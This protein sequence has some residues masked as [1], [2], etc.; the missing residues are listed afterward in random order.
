MHLLQYQNYYSEISCQL[1][2]QYLGCCFVKRM[3]NS[4]TKCSHYIEYNAIRCI[5]IYII[6]FILFHRNCFWNP[7]IYVFLNPS[8]SLEYKNLVTQCL[9]RFPFWICVLLRLIFYRKVNRYL[10]VSKHYSSRK[11]EW[12]HTEDGVR[13]ARH[14]T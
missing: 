2:G 12:H 5:L 14:C 1:R 8:V 11:V 10:S 4:W 13:A 9:F 3:L 7:I 6:L